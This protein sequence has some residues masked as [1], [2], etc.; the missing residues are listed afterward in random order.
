MGV[1]TRLTG[2]TNQGHPLILATY[3][4]MTLPQF[5]VAAAAFELT[6]TLL[7][8]LSGQGVIQIVR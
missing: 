6:E 4:H 1:V 3:K 2:D 5:E 7:L 8:F